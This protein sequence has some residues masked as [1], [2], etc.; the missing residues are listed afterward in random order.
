MSSV[1][2]AVD[3]ALSI[4]ICRHQTVMAALETGPLVSET[5]NAFAHSDLLPRVD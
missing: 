4:V 1:D 2:C 5:L 3:F